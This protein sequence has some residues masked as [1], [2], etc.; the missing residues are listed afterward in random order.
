VVVVTKSDLATPLGLA[1]LSAR[2]PGIDLLAASSYTGAGL[3][4]IAS[5][6]APNATGVLLGPSG[7]GKSS[8]V[9]ALLGETTQQ[10]GDVRSGDARGRH[11]TTSRQLLAVPTGGT[12]IDTPGLRSLGLAAD[13]NSVQAAF[14]DVSDLAAN[15]RFSDCRHESEPGCAVNDAVAAGRLDPRRLASY[16]KLQREVAFHARRDNPLERQ[17]QTRQWRARAKANRARAP[18]R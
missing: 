10:I 3:D 17:A 14:S 9:N 13:Q 11:T 12:L 6:L 1:D 15:C 18:K 5:M 4:A 7:A 2:L 16:R 8:L